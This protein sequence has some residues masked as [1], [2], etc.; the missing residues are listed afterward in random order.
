MS[1]TVFSALGGLLALFA[2]TFF[3]L[4]ARAQ[5]PTATD[6][7]FMRPEPFNIDEVV[8]IGAEPRWIRPKLKQCLRLKEQKYQRYPM[9]MSYDYSVENDTSVWHY[10]FES[11]GLLALPSLRQIRKDSLL[12]ISTTDNTIYAT[13][14]A[15]QTD[16]HKLQIMGYEHFMAMLDRSFIRTHEFR[17]KTPIPSAKSDTVEL[18][19]WSRKYRHDRGTLLLDTA[20]CEIVAATRHTGLDYNVHERCL[21]LVRM[22]LQ[23]MNG[24]RWHLWEIDETVVYRRIGEA[25]YPAT[26]TFDLREERSGRE[27]KTTRW[28]GWW[29]VRSR[30]ELRPSSATPPTAF[31]EVEPHVWSAVIYIENKTRLR[32][33]QALRD[34][35]HQ[36]II[37]SR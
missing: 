15:A 2:A 8:I 36:L 23:W 12:R 14:S 6:S 27:N 18:V 7:L 33:E 9:L 4:P 29:N 37:N 17:Q 21:P 30:L 3:A 5:S 35:E 22:L 31:I 24:H 16:F 26:I 28:S 11:H 32:R 34:V 20:R 10:N 13:D 1:T 19:F 25:L